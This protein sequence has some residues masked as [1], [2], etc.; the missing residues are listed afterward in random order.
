MARE[1]QL[2]VAVGTKGVGKTY[3]TCMEIQEYLT[4]NPSTGKK[5]R[6]VLIFDV[7]KEYTNEELQKNGFR[8]RTKVIALKD[9]EDWSKQKR[10]EVR[11][12][13]P[14]DA[15]GNEIGTDQYGEI[16]KVILSYYR[17]GMLILEDINK[18]LI[19]T[20]DAT[21][22]GAITTNR[23]RDLDIYVHY[24][25][26]SA[27]TTRIWQNANVV[28]FH[29]QMDDIDRYKAR[30][31]NYDLFKIAQLMVNEQYF[32]GNQRF[33]C[34]VLNQENKIK[35]KY[36][37]EMFVKACRQYLELHPNKV[38][39]IQQKYGKGWD[40]RVKAIKEIVLEYY[41]KYF[42]NKKTKK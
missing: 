32:S 6:K 24:Q 9:L 29:Y 16:L 17:G 35:G 4:P 15:L 36:S 34:Y 12:V 30:I 42:G 33:F 31:P 3:K 26:L 11:R 21:I 20:R 2:V 22:I 14:L 23:H 18:Y 8:F 28:R 1:P 10:V 27:L 5:P 19:E 38:K 25:S 37:T 13:L 41:K 7:N 39:T 40:G